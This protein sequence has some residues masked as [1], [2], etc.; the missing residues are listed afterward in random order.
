MDDLETSKCG[1][2]DDNHDKLQVKHMHNSHQNTD[3]K[4]WGVYCRL[5]CQSHSKLES[6]FEYLLSFKKVQF[7]T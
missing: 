4:Q 1:G 6:H 3:W 7:H 5:F 2:D